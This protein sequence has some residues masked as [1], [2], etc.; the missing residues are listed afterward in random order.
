MKRHRKPEP[1]LFDEQRTDDQRRCDIVL[2]F[3]ALLWAHRAGVACTSARLEE[4]TPEWKRVL[5]ELAARGRR[6]H[7]ELVGSGGF[8]VTYLKGAK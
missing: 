4:I 7:S 6:T 5:R 3:R 8:L 2:V 1:S